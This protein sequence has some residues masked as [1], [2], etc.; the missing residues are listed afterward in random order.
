MHPQTHRE[1]SCWCSHRGDEHFP[2]RGGLSC[3]S[4]EARAML[5]A[6]QVIQ[7]RRRHERVSL[8]QPLRTSIAGAPA[9]VVDAS[10][11]GVGVLHHRLELQHDTRYRL[12]FY[13]QYGPITLECEFARTIPNQTLGAAADEG[14][15]RTGLKI[16]SIDSESEARLHHLV[17]GLTEH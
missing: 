3:H 16:I 15:W 9:H 4:C 7:E 12:L 17:T 2:D 5:D 14:A 13:S 1:S 6:P 10:I 11:G 8:P